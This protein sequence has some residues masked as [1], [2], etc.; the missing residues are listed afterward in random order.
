MVST[1]KKCYLNFVKKDIMI[2][3]L[4]GYYLNFCQKG[5]Y[6]NLNVCPK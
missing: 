2:S 6:G 4:K 3:T 5:Y 1:L